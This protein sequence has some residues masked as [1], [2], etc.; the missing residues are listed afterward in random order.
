MYH[1]AAASSES[2]SVIGHS[3][4]E[5]RGTGP[6]EVGAQQLAALIGRVS[7]KWATGSGLL[8]VST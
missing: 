6:G 1:G 7:Q 8:H 5:V 2:E 4:L 3:V